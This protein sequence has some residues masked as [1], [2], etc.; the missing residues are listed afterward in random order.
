VPRTAR[1]VESHAPSSLVAVLV[2]VV[3]V[4]VAL[5]GG[6]SASSD[7]SPVPVRARIGTFE[8]ARLVEACRRRGATGRTIEELEHSDP[9]RSGAAAEAVAE[10][11]EVERVVAIAEL[12]TPSA[13]PWCAQGVECL[14]VTEALA[15]RIARGPPR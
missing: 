7:D 6:I 14:D 13:A 11:A 5:F 3:A 4:V 15:Q 9:L 8:R 10:V 12:P 1:V 2:L